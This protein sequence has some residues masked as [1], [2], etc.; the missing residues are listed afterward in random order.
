MLYLKNIKP[1]KCAKMQYRLN[2]STPYTKGTFVL[3]LAESNLEFD[4]ILS[5]IS[6]S[7]SPIVLIQTKTVFT[8]IRVFEKILQYTI[9]SKVDKKSIMQRIHSVVPT[10]TTHPIT[11][12]ELRGKNFIYNTGEV[13]GAIRG[14]LRLMNDNILKAYFDSIFEKVASVPETY[15]DRYII[16]NANGADVFRTKA[17]ITQG[18][19]KARSLH[20]TNLLLYYIKFHSKDFVLN[21][22]KSKATLVFYTNRGVFKYSYSDIKEN[23]IAQY[24]ESYNAKRVELYGDFPNPSQNVFFKNLYGEDNIVTDDKIIDLTLTGIRKIGSNDLDEDDDGYLLDPEEKYLDEM[25]D[26]DES[27]FDDVSSVETFNILGSEDNDT[28]VI[29]RDEDN[30]I[31]PMSVESK[32]LTEKET[33]TLKSKRANE[34]VMVLAT[35]DD[36][37]AVVTAI[38]DVV[39]ISIVNK[40]SDVRLSS[41]KDALMR[42]KEAQLARTRKISAKEANLLRKMELTYNM[43]DV[44][45]APINI[46]P[47]LFH[48]VDTMDGMA[49]N[50]FINFNKT[51]METTF[52]RD[53]VG[54]FTQMSKDDNNPLYLDKYEIVEASDRFNNQKML[55]ATLKDVDGNRHN[56]KVRIPNL[57]GSVMTL[58]GNKMELQAQKIVKPVV[59]FGDRV[60]ITMDFNKGFV[61]MSGKY[62]NQQHS[63]IHRFVNQIL[64][65]PEKKKIIK[66]IEFGTVDNK[67]DIETTLEFKTIGGIIKSI[68]KDD[69]NCVYF[70]HEKRIA[71]I[72]NKS[73]Y[74]GDILDYNP[75]HNTLV[76]G[77]VGGQPLVL[78]KQLDCMFTRPTNEEDNINGV[79]WWVKN[80]IERFEDE[81]TI[82][83]L[84]N[85]KSRVSLAYSVIR[86]MSR[87][88]P[89]ILV[90][91]YTDGLDVVLDRA[92]VPHEILEGDSMKRRP[93]HREMALRFSDCTVMCNVSAIEN[94]ILLSGLQNVDLSEFTY[95]EFCDYTSGAVA[96]ILSSMG[97][98]NLP[99]YVSTFKTAFVSP[100]ARDVLSHYNMPTDFCGVLLYANGLLATDVIMHDSDPRLYRIRSAE[101]IP[102]VFYK[103]TADAFSQ[104]TI[105]KKR[106]SK[107]AKLEIQENSLVRAIQEQANVA[108]YSTVNPVV[109][110]DSK[111][112]VTVKGPNGLNMDRAMSV[113]KR[114]ESQL[115]T[116]VIAMPSV[117][118]GSVGIVKR[119]PIDPNIIGTR[120][121]IKTPENEE[122]IESFEAKQLLSPSELVTPSTTNK[123]EGMRVCMNFQ[124]KGHGMGTLYP[125]PANYTNGYDTM[126]GYFAEEFCHYA[127]K[128]GVISNITEDFII[129]DYADGTQDAY[130]TSNIERHSAKAKYI[131]NTM[132]IM[133]GLKIGAKVKAQ[134]PLAY[135][136]RMFVE[137]DGIPVYCT[138]QLAFVAYQSSDCVYED[139]TIISE[140]I[141]KSMASYDYKPKVVT[142]NKDDIVK[143]YISNIGA[144]VKSGDP[145]IQY[146]HATEDAG[147][148][149]ILANNEDEIDA[150]LIKEKNASNAGDISEISI[151]YSCN[152]SDMSNSIRNLINKVEAEYRSRGDGLLDNM[153]NMDTFKRANLSR[154]PAQVPEGTKVGGR[155]IKKDEIIVEY[156]VRSYSMMGHADKLTF[157]DALKGETSKILP[158]ELMPV[159]VE[160]G[161]VVET[162]MSPNSP[163]KRK[164]ASMIVAGAV[165]R[166]IFDALEQCRADLGLKSYNE[167]KKER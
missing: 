102:A 108:T 128:N 67:D 59:K 14:R 167:R 120:G 8:P 146:I 36:D 86:I 126:I 84:E 117:Y 148:N 134:Q 62:I 54:C 34:G 104:Y 98:G 125:S 52:E 77:Y 133:K 58:N 43:D 71:N 93:T 92:G 142:L 13:F 166:M 9:S 162:C 76:V 119:M 135:N 156:V 31:V 74:A 111:L 96:S 136:A 55:R 115:S 60:M 50:K 129:V 15:D 103:V 41:T 155:K 53:I 139:S 151:Y 2:S 19:Y 118:S 85:I 28:I 6:D 147:L 114:Q 163:I 122:E 56:V 88:L 47:M 5:D 124:Q 158:D 32:K 105:S 39:D 97:N 22:N 140:Y 37:S 46:E 143:S 141:Q 91:S 132:S 26:E 100:I 150:T 82:N 94:S 7:K 165:E 112:K 152:K 63:V 83:V 101:I 80:F 40:E 20:I 17:G 33:A 154:I 70:D 66:H 73:Y 16:V 25:V 12:N 109:S 44:S 113:A 4:T 10:L 145:L 123:D 21:M 164:V 24:A 110:A 3:P 51:Y 138:G 99:L 65:D 131:D 160:S 57:D 61:L 78:D 30:M 79:S 11:R 127:K 144:R 42:L 75:E 157:F 95:G 1:F 29:G 116:G 153:E 161:I 23:V 35:A 69:D 121:Y 90:L 68:Y 149:S 38:D 106:G 48:N 64:S 18:M 45:N 72:G 130:R 81:K 27:G 137:V 49:E 107:K 159:G 89:I 87:N